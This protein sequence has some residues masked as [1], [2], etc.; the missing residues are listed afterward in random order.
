MSGA[1]KPVAGWQAI[2]G[3]GHRL[4]TPWFIAWAFD[5]GTWWIAGEGMPQSADSLESAQF[6]AE[7]ALRGIADQLCSLVAGERAV[8]PELLEARVARLA[9]VA[10]AARALLGGAAEVL[11]MRRRARRCY[12][13]PAEALERALDAAVAAALAGEP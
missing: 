8:S 7:D 5:D 13:A 6:A 4:T 2:A 9:T 12:A 11:D 3:T 1:R 10:E